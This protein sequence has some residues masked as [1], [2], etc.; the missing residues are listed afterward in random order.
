MIL[1]IHEILEK[2][3]KTTYGKKGIKFVITVDMQVLGRTELYGGGHKIQNSS[4]KINK[5]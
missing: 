4:Y 1:L 2:V 3:K 5:Y